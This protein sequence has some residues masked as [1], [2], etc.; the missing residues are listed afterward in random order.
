MLCRFG[1]EPDVRTALLRDGT[2]LPPGLA[3]YVALP[4]AQGL[5]L[6]EVLADTTP[7]PEDL[8]GA[9][10]LLATLAEAAVE[11][12]HAGSLDHLAGALPLVESFLSLVNDAHV[13]L[14]GS[15]DSG[16]TSWLP[17][18]SATNTSPAGEST[19]S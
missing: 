16:S 4:L 19:T 2:R 11:D 5:P 6:A 15:P 17:D 10:R 12:Q 18:R 8:H 1:G 13:T 9:A 14:H 7:E 3:S